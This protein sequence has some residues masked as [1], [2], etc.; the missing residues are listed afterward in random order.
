MKVLVVG[1]GGREHAICKAVAKSPLCDKLY[2]A[3]GNAGIAEV[4]ECLPIIAEDTHRMVAAVK[5]KEIGFVI[6]GPE[7]ALALGLADELES[8]GVPCFGP[9]KLAAEIESSKGFM[10]DLCD[11]AGV[12]TASYKRFTDVEA[13]RKY[14][15]EQRP[16]IVVKANGLAEGKGV[17]IAL[18]IE[19]ALAAV[20]AAMVDKVF[21]E[22]GTEVV[23]EDFMSGEEASFFALCDG[24]RARFFCTAQ[25]HKALND[26]DKGP[27]TG[28]M[29]AYSPAP[30][31]D[32]AMRKRIM[33]EIID[34]TVEELKNMGRPFTGM[35]YAGLMMTKTGPRLI[36]YNARFGD[37]ETEAML[38][39]L[40]S[41]L[42]E[43]LYSCA[44]GRLLGVESQW[45]AGASLSVIMAAEGYP[46]NY[47][48]GSVIRGMDRA[49]AIPDVTVY[50]S[51][52]LRNQAGELTANGG[53]V[54]CVTATGSDIVEAQRKAYEAV[55]AIDWPEGYYRR[56]IGWKAVAKVKGAKG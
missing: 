4:A 45:E 15:E 22:S 47:L 10:K 5:E 3:P 21:G 53:R 14:V 56:D 42:L 34:P 2:C 7:I 17:T 19:D 23:I 38:P 27:N 39:L 30:M 18:T 1:K 40:K 8:I 44:C 31:I 46:S 26:G 51:A 25:D 43:L 24:E 55:D 41:D 20:D 13:A 54:L 50:H 52:T 12:P 48:K 37:P 32:E 11:R 36:E 35:L 49:Q 28:G 9:K 6:I 29:G 16:P 33:K